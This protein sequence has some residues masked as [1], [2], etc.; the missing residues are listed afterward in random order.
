VRLVGIIVVVC[1]MPVTVCNDDVA[2]I[3][4]FSD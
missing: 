3:V 2:A 1:F 4:S